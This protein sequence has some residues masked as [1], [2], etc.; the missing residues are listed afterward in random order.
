[1]YVSHRLPVA[2]LGVAVVAAIVHVA[3]LA[4]LVLLAGNLFLIG[5]LAADVLLAPRARAMRVERRS[6]DVLGIGRTADIGIRVHNPK[7]RRIEVA[8]RDASPPSLRRD[9]R[10]HRAVVPA[11]A[12]HRFESQ[13]RPSRRGYVTVGPVTVRTSGPIGLGGRQSTIRTTARLKVYPALPS[14]AEVELRVQRARMLEIGERSSAVRGGGTDFDSL[15]EYHPDDE[16]RRINW[17]ATARSTKP[18][19]NLYRQERNQQVVLLI[20][21]GRMMATSFGGFS[22][23]EYALD[24]GIAVAELAARVGDQ[25]GLVGFAGRVLA[26]VG[27]KGG[28]A[29]PRRLVETLFALEPSL[30]A[31]NYGDAFST[32]LARHRRRALL[33]LLTELTEESALEPLFD[34]LPGLLGRHLVLVGAVADPE[35][36]RVARHVPTS[37]ESVYAK[38]AAVAAVD[39]RDRAAA[40]LR[41]MGAVVV[42]RPPGKLAGELAD[43][44]LRIKAFGRL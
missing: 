8:V 17:R 28:R 38:A 37:S 18:I 15:R 23:F 29:Q 31:A 7:D 24:A 21:A 32:L 19:T 40:R 20:D 30:E 27:P 3:G 13:V 12:W 22:R 6:P 43:H 16:F 42:D 9:P 4:W 5:L 39:A 2:A 11:G 34:A 1:M 33:V 44:Y 10:R 25:V 41:R 35:V 14:R 36:I 26:M